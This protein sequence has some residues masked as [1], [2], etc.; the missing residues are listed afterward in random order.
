MVISKKKI[1]LPEVYEVKCCFDI[2][3]YFLSNRLMKFTD[4]QR[5][6]IINTMNNWRD[7]TPTCK[8]AY[9]EIFIRWVR[10]KW[11]Y[12]LLMAINQNDYLWAQIYLFKKIFYLR[13]PMIMI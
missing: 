11:A 8:S 3:L 13:W 10:I 5:L 12:R 6:W 7:P 9:D 4:W 1:N 2:M